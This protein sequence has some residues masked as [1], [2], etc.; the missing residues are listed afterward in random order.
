MKHFEES[1]RV[2][3]C[4][5][6]LQTFVMDCFQSQKVFNKSLHKCELPL[7]HLTVAECLFNV[8]VGVS[9]RLQNGGN[10]GDEVDECLERCCH[11]VINHSC[12]ALG[13]LGTQE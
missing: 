10:R 13:L 7:N 12:V 1:V 8:G 2:K 6:K 11:L 5:Y 9:N 3:C 4:R